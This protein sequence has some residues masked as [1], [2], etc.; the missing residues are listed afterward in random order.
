MAM[1]A[2]VAACGLLVGYLLINC[3]PAFAGEG[4]GLL[5][6]EQRGAYHACLYAAWVQDYC[7]ENYPRSAVSTCI[8]ANGGGRFP[9][10]GRRWTHNF[11][12]YA[13]LNLSR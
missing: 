11:C 13:A 1:K 8:V 10:E 5:T 6:P 3:S 4:W 9:L 7:E 2:L 12:W